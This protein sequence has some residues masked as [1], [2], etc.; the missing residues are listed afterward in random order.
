MFRKCRQI[1]SGIKSDRV[2]FRRD[3]V[4]EIS[5]VTQVNK[6]LL[7]LGVDSAVVSAPSTHAPTTPSVTRV[8]TRMETPPRAEVA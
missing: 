8:E 2:F 4:E 7:F 1:E 6:Q 5:H 3:S